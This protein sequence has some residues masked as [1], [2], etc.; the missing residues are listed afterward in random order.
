VGGG[1]NSVTVD[2]NEEVNLII[3]GFVSLLSLSD[4]CEY[5]SVL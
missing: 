3:G 1:G 4:F 2:L 5:G